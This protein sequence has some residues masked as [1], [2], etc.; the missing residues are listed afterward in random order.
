MNAPNSMEF[1]NAMLKEADAHTSH[2]H[3]E[4]WLK[5]DVPSWQDILPF[6]W[7]FKQNVVS[8]QEG[9]TNIRLD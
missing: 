7:A 1:L 4:V 2:D 8:T 6:S 5:T 3:W 9:Y